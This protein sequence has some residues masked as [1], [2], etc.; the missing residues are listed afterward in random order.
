[1]VVEK[2]S[3]YSGHEPAGRMIKNK[4]Q[5]SVRIKR[6]TVVFDTN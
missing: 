4:M 1:M 6:K 3:G 2:D 5:A